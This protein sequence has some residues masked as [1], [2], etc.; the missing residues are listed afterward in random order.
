MRH[1]AKTVVAVD[2]T[3]ISATASRGGRR[4]T[5][6]GTARTAKP[7]P[8]ILWSVEARKITLVMS[9]HCATPPPWRL[10]IWEILR[11]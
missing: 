7:K 3:V 4:G 5:S 10:S 1:Q 8:V 11:A 6:S 9:S 2:S